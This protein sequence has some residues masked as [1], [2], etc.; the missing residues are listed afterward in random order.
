MHFK[1]PTREFR[2]TQTLPL[3]VT[4]A[5]RNLRTIQNFFLATQGFSFSLSTVRPVFVA[6]ETFEVTVKATDAE[7]KPLGQDF[8]LHVLERTVVDGKVGES[9]VEQHKLAID[10]KSG[11]VRQTLR[12]EKGAQYI[13]RAEGID[14]FKNPVTGQ[15]VVKISDDKDQVR[16]R[17][18]ADG[19]RS[20]SA[21]RPKCS[22]IGARRRPWRSSRSKARGCS[23]TSSC[24]LRPARTS[25][26]SR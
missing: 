2:E 15:T 10:A 1:F 26:R 3:V 8:V 17:I 12:L 24:S 19:T 5:E 23:I 7:G 21:T 11:E 25:L 20:K 13:V 9:E 14:R 22:C 16:L 6:G 4:L 18:L